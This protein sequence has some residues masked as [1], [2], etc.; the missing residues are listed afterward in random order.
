MDRDIVFVGINYRLGALGFLSLGSKEVPG[1]AALKDQVLALRWI[2]DNIQYFGGDPNQVTMIGNSAAGLMVSV[3]MTSPMAQRLFNR[4]I[5]MSGSVIEYPRAQPH[6]LHLALRLAKYFKCSG[7]TPAFI[8]RC[9]MEKSAKEI[10]E[11]QFTLY[12][13]ARC[14]G[15]LWMYVMEPD[16]GQE[17]LLV[18]EPYDAMLKGN[19]MKIPI[20]IGVTQDELIGIGASFTSNATLL[21]F[22]DE[23]FYYMAPICLNYERE[24][25]R[26]YQISQSL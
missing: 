5:L 15:L 1:N 20:I 8:L 23:N 10:I 26:S 4:A 2:R 17:R 13:I 11:S 7:E 22:F 12:E 14:P 18:D 3:L 21:K 6:Q 19:Y 16:F 24:T 9:L 25:P